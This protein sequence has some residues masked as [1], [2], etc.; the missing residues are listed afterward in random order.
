MKIVN[1]KEKKIK[2]DFN[3]LGFG[4]YFTDYMLV[5]D[6]DNGAWSEP[7]ICPN[8]EFDMSGLLYQNIWGSDILYD[9]NGFYGPL[10]DGS[11]E[12]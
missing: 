3:N 2:P 10:N 5:M 8:K 4:K 7:C 9:F 12:L 1:V 11:K 6:Y